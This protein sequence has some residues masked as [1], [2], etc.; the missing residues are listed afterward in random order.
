MR[1]IES[2]PKPSATVL[3]YRK[4]LDKVLNEW[5]QV[6]TKAF[7]RDLDILI[8]QPRQGSKT[9]TLDPYLRCL[10]ISDYINVI[11]NEVSIPKS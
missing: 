11:L 10:P 3:H 4:L 9:L 7:Q 1:S 2:K 6:A 5:E 8:A